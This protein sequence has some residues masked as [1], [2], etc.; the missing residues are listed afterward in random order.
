[1]NNVIREHIA[2]MTDAERKEMIDNHS[3]LEDN[4][5]IDDCLLR[6]TARELTRR[7]GLPGDSSIILWMQSV[8]FECYR[9]YGIKY[10]N[11]FASM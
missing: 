7:S 6:R 4:G 11:E 2:Q 9:F 5:F 3:F 8:A 1:M 10:L